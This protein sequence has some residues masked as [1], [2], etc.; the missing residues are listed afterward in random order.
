[1]ALPNIASGDPRREITIE[2]PGERTQNQK[3]MLGG[4]LAAGVLVSSLGLYWHLDSRDASNEVSAGAFTGEG[5]TEEHV[6]LVERAE[7]SKTRA[8]IAYSIGGAFLIG[9]VAAW[10]LTDPKSEK[11]V[12]R[13]GVIVTPT[14]DGGAMA[15]KAWS[16]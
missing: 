15:S 11:T 8:T 6:G 12:I 14:S 2:V 1:M 7:R 4:L 3:L 10:I 16:F 9:T 13:T 5:W